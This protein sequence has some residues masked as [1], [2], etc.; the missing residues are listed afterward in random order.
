MQFLASIRATYGK[1]TGQENCRKWE[2]QLQ[3]NFSSHT[4]E[5]YTNSCEGKQG[6]TKCTNGDDD[7][8]D[9]TILS[10]FHFC[11]QSQLYQDN[12]RMVLKGS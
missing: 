9:S 6:N 4:I 12:R 7:E 10:L 8:A 11:F 3:A 1:L 5:L 2:I